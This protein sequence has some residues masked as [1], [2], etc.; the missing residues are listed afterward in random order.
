MGSVKSCIYCDHPVIYSENTDD[1]SFSDVLCGHPDWEG[2][3]VYICDIR[4]EPDECP[5]IKKEVSKARFELTTIIE[6]GY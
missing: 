2:E 3:D 1:P 6:D 5:L 4:K